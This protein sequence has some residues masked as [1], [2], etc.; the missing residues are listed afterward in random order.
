MTTPDEDVIERSDELDKRIRGSGDIAAL[1]HASRRNWLVLRVMIA[2][3]ALQAIS[4][5]AVGAT[6][7]RAQQAATQVTATREAAYQNCLSGN[8]IRA[9]QLQLWLYILALPPTSP[10]RQPTAAQRK[11]AADFKVYVTKVFTP[12]T[13]V[14]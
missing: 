8:E 10:D 3:I 6:L 5:A 14:R 13:C 9:G 2:V 12:R 4:F 1:I 7:I 11:Q